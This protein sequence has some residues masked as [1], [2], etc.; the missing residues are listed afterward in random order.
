[1]GGRG[2]RLKGEMR[3]ASRV[4]PLVR[5][6][7]CSH[8]CVT[9][10]FLSSSSRKS[11]TKLLHLSI[12]SGARCSIRIQLYLIIGAGGLVVIWALIVILSSSVC[13]PFPF[14]SYLDVPRSPHGY[15]NVL[16]DPFEVVS[17]VVTCQLEPCIGVAWTFGLVLFTL[18]S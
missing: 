2:T 8:N 7:L 11:P 3:M 13:H 1:M 12:T 18:F 15:T 14:G 10:L 4:V 9:S 6:T 17:S 16:H 5:I